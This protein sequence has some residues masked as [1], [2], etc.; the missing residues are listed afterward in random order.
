MSEFSDFPG[1]LTAAVDASGKRPEDIAEELGG[2]V[3]A[4]SIYRWMAG[5]SAPGIEALPLLCP[6]LG[7]S[8]D[9]LVD[10]E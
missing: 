4:R 8:A 10:L 7:V 5:R 6:V 2:A 3:S 9:W 1:R